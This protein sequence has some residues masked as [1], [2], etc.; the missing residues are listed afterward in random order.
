MTASAAQIGVYMGA[1]RA[2]RFPRQ[3]NAESLVN[4][5]GNRMDLVDSDPLK[6]QGD[7]TDG[8]PKDTPLLHSTVIFLRF[9]DIAPTS[10]RRNRSRIREIPKDSGIC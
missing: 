5:V 6:L 8:I 4:M 3:V 9:P 1:D 10:R 7:L 2:G